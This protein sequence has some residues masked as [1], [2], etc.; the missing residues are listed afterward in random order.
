[1]MSPSPQKGVHYRKLKSDLSV[2]KTERI[3]AALNQP[4]IL[5]ALER[6]PIESISISRLG[7]KSHPAWYDS[8]SKSV[9]ID[10]SRKPGVQYGRE[11]QPGVT[12]NMSSATPDKIESMRR[13]L[14]Q[15]TAHHIENSVPGVAK[16][17]MTAFS[18]SGKRPITRYAAQE[19][20]EYF[21]ESLVA[22]VVERDALAK[23]DP[24][25]SK[26]VKQAMALMRKRI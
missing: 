26:M 14:L 18:D 4:E 2:G 23:H 11:F 24:V 8:D 9:S 7:N 20:K 17:M 10:S 5:A 3:I 12:A 21:A 13:S 6:N 22:Y 1:M 15:E 19:P 25:G 16:L